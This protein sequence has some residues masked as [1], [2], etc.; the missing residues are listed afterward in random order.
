M[1][2]AHRPRERLEVFRYS[3]QTLR[4]PYRLRALPQHIQLGGVCVVRRLERCLWDRLLAVGYLD[5]GFTVEV[6]RPSWHDL[7]LFRIGRPQHIGRVG[8]VAAIFGDDSAVA[9]RVGGSVFWSVRAVWYHGSAGLEDR[10]R[11]AAV[12][13]V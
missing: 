3:R 1:L 12:R 8:E 5:V 2:P 9:P 7:V 13:L 11:P 10:A 4:R 6:A